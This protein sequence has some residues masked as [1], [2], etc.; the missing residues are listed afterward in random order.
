MKKQLKLYEGVSDLTNCK[1][2]YSGKKEV[3]LSSGFNNEGSVAKS[4]IT[5]D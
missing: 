2:A 5:D 4:S 1:I 3:S